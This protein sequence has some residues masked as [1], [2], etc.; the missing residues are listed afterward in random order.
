MDIDIHM[1]FF[2]GEQRSRRFM[3][4]APATPQ[5]LVVP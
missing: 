4:V 1:S 5:T 3:I 2:F